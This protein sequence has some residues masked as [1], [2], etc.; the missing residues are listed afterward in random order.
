MKKEQLYKAVTR[1]DLIKELEQKKEVIL[2]FDLPRAQNAT[3]KAHGK[4]I[5]RKIDRNLRRE[6]EVLSRIRSIDNQIEDLRKPK[7]GTMNPQVL[8][9]TVA[10]IAAGLEGVVR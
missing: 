10:G 2:K 5:K 4:G 9:P 3:A 6:N 7:K 1:E 8:L